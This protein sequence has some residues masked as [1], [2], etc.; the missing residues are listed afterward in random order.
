DRLATGD[1]SAVLRVRGLQ[2]LHEDRAAV[3]GVARVAVNVH[4]PGDTR[5]RRGQVL[6]SPDRWRATEVIDARIDGEPVA[7]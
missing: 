7:E 6:L 2:S 1:G 3:S 5:L 4:G